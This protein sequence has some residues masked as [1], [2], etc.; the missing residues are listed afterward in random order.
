[1]KPKIGVFSF[2]SCEGCQ[3]QILNLE[4]ELVSLLGQIEFVNFREAMSEKGDD[5]QIAFVEGSITRESEIEVVKEIRTRAEILIAL[6]ACAHLGGVNNLKHLHP[7]GRWIPSVYGRDDLFT[8]TMPTKRVEDIVPVDYT[9]PGCPIDKLE[10]LRCVQALLVKTA[11]RLPDYPVCVECRSKGNVCLVEQGKWCLG[12]VT[13]AGCDAICPTF[14]DPC[15][16]CRG[17]LKEA[18][19]ESLVTILKEKGLTK[20]DIRSKFELFNEMEGI[21]I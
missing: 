18:N 4:E 7:R 17:I 15:A 9:I 1:M 12:P 20:D 11:P 13:R 3:L 8:D 6:G 16:G 2:T 10:F 5:Y 14:R 21:E 19:I